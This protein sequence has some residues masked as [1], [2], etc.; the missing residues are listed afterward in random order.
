M[1]AALTGRAENAGA[2]LPAG[3][4]EGEAGHAGGRGDEES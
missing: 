2:V 3:E 4:G 1:T